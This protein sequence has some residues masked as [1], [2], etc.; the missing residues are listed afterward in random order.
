MKVAQPVIVN[1]VMQVYVELPALD[2][3]GKLPPSPVNKNIKKVYY[4][5]NDLRADVL[6]EIGEYEC[7]DQKNK[8]FIKEIKDEN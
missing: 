2:M 5:D 8:V 3:I 7:W 4:D 1:Y 6:K